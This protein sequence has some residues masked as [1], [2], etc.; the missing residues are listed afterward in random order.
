MAKYTV[1]SLVNEGKFIALSTEDRDYH[2]SG[3]VQINAA[4]LD[5]WITGNNEAF[6]DF[7][8]NFALRMYRVSESSVSMHLTWINDVGANA[9]TQNFILPIAMLKR[10]LSGKTVNAVVDNEFRFYDPD[11]AREHLFMPRII[12]AC[13]I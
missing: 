8:L 7:D 5:A 10:V 2:I 11:V 3:A 12:N 13:C 4:M 1:I 6:Y 9:Y